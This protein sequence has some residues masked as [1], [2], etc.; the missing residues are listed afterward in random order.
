MKKL[1]LISNDYL[2]FHNNSVSTDYNDTINIIQAISK[3]NFLYFLCRKKN[4][5]G[6]FKATLKKK[7]KLKFFDIFSLDFSDKLIFMISITPFNFMTFFFLKLFNKK[8][9]GFVYLRSDGHKEYFI[10]YGFLGKIIYQFFFKSILKYLNVITVSKN[11]T[12]INNY[13]AS[14]I[15]PSEIDYGWKKNLKKTYTEKAKLFYL[16]RV[17]KEKGVFSLINLVNKFSID[18]DLNILGATIIKKSLSNKIKYHLETS[19]KEKIIE[20]FDKNNI[21]ILPSYTEGYPK[22]V[23]ESLSRLRP[24]IIFNDISHVKAN[25]KG[26]FVSKRKSKSLQKT[27]IYILNNYKKI[28]QSMKNNKISS[29]LKFQT[30]LRNLIKRN[31]Y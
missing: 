9:N 31:R 27:I 23:L 5:K 20:F 21:F 2:K 11:L 15:Y 30:D 14:R 26:V 19:K 13:K 17:K 28:Q 3:N 24:V 1:I 29:K 12:N 4:K 8:L 10:K 16:G 6:I 18:F 22:V 7:K 25:F